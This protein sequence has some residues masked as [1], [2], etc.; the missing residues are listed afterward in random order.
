MFLTS[1]QYE[2]NEITHKGQYY[3]VEV[4]YKILF[5]SYGQFLKKSKKVENWLILG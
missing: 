5:Q 3:G 2:F 1:Q 4:L